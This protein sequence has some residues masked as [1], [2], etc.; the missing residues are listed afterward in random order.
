MSAAGASRSMRSIANSVDACG[1]V[2]S[3]GSVVP[4]PSQRASANN[5]PDELTASP[6]LI[7]TH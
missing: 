4:V 5:I 6:L 1:I 7:S 2:P 3:T